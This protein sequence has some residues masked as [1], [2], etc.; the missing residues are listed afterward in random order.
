MPDSPDSG[1]PDLAGYVGAAA[2][3]ALFVAACDD[4]ARAAVDGYLGPAAGRVPPAVLAAAVREVGADLYHRRKTRNG[5]ASFTGAEGITPL[6]V[7]RDSMSAAYPLLRPY[8]APPI[9]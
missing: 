1:A 7:S 9:A 3:D 8:V 6:R 4:A 2:G 5:V